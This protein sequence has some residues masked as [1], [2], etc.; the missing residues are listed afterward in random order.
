V[1]PIQDPARLEWE[2]AMVVEHFRVG[3][4]ELTSAGR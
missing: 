2:A 1:H 4:A 3:A